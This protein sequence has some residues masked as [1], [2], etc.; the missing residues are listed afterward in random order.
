VALAPAGATSYAVAWSARILRGQ[1]GV[2]GMSPVDSE[3]V[4]DKSHCCGSTLFGTKI[5]CSFNSFHVRS[6]FPFQELIPMA[7]FSGAPDSRR[8]V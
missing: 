6:L 8:A 7:F 4:Y 5:N 1:P 2:G 3:V